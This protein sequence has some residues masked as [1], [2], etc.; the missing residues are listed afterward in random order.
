MKIQLNL[1]KHCIQT[2]TKRLYNQS[3]SEYFKKGSD[4][5]GLEKH[6]E[7]LKTI[8]EKCDFP[9]LRSKHPELAGNYTG[10]ASIL[11]DD[12]SRIVILVSGKAIDLLTTR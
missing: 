1:S 5:Q 12:Q 7:I 9:R 3:V 6:I 4:I 11:I 8:L 10:E 2:E